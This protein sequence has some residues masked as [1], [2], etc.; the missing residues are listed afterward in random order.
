MTR[1]RWIADESTED[2]AALVGEQANHL[3]RVL[4]ARVGQ[5]FEIAA[6]GR[7]RLGKVAAI[8][9]ERVEF[10]LGEEIDSGTLPSVHLLLSI[11]KF[12]RMDWAIEKATELGVSAITPVIAQRSERNLC[13]AA[14][15]R[16]ERW[17]RIAREAAQQSR[18]ATPP[19]ILAPI[20]LSEAVNVEAAVRI[21]LAPEGSPLL[22]VLQKSGKTS[23]AS[24][25]PEGTP[26]LPAAGRSGDA[27]LAIGPEGGWTDTELQLFHHAGW[28]FASLG[29]TILRT[30]TAAIAA[31]TTITQILA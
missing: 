10:D 30:E 4:R 9:P 5:E 25:D 11:F 17:R 28:S 24:A 19:E 21:V 18:R 29:P 16:V 31:L 8:S 26:L 12:D 3:A 23:E 20:K 13:A 14:D 27:A 22:S 15:K 2:T 6:D 1:R 7:V